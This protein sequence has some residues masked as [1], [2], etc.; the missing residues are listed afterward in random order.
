MTETIDT[1]LTEFGLTVDEIHKAK[2]EVAKQGAN[3]IHQAGR[4]FLGLGDPSA[5]S[6]FQKELAKHWSG[7]LSEAGLATCI[8]QSE[9][10]P[11]LLRD[12]DV[13]ASSV[14][15]DPVMFRD[16]TAWCLFHAARD[17][18][19][20][21]QMNSMAPR[22]ESHL[23]GGLLEA[24]KMRCSHWSNVVD[25]ALERRST[26]LTLDFVD[27]S[28]LGGE[29]ATGGDFAVILEIDGKGLQ[30]SLTASPSDRMIIPL[31]FQAK[32][33]VR[34][35]ADVSQKHHERGYQHALLGRNP[36]RSAYIFYENETKNLDATKISAPFPPLIKDVRHVASPTTTPVLQDSCDLATFFMTSLADSLVAPR[37]ESADAALRMVFEKADPAQLCRLAIISSE[38]DAYGQYFDILNAL[39]PNEEHGIQLNQW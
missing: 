17:T 3:P 12:A 28:I 16:L 29:Q 31:L 34:P 39:G 24:L 7:L 9:G 6:N 21:T 14:L 1:F 11:E 35:N 8:L 38:A 13:V 33:Y 37:A 10:S 25:A 30:P 4:R 5:S 18:S 23:S 20:S 19:I 32:R 36:C 27:H 22:S 2:V 15:A 26:R